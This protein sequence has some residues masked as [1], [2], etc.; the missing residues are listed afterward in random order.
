MLAALRG[1]SRTSPRSQ[2]LPWQLHCS[3]LL[4]LAISTHV[5]E[6][7]PIGQML[8]LS[9]HSVPTNKLFCTYKTHIADILFFLIT[10][11][12]TSKQQSR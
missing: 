4:A 7:S 8:S 6:Q 11:C 1:C 2:T 5:L 12:Q 9:F 10:Y 3:V